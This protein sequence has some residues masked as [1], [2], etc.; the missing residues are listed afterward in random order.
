MPT[1]LFGGTFDPIHKGHLAVAQAALESPRFRLERIY[2]IPA[3]IPPHKQQQPVT[4]YLHRYAMLE[5]ALRD[6]PHFEPSRIED[7]EITRGEP[8]YSI[9]TV[10][11]FKR[12]HPNESDDLYFI[13]GIDSFQKVTTWRE[14][15]ALLDECNFIVASRP[16]YDEDIMDALMTSISAQNVTLL[17]TVAVDI[18]STQ[19]RQA[20]ANHE[21]LDKYVLPSV[22]DYIQQHRLYR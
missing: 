16:G 12:D 10:R 7:P 22:A 9:D 1:A 21:P 3:D 2:F 18:S 17:E 11:R 20:V 6:Y 15:D 4:P 19:I 8:N 14:P 13:I 5:L